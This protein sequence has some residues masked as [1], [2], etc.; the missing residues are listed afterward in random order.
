MLHVA[1][2]CACAC[3]CAWHVLLFFV[4]CSLLEL[5]RL[6]LA[7]CFVFVSCRVLCVQRL[8][9]VSSIVS[10]SPRSLPCVVLV[11]VVCVVLFCGSRPLYARLLRL[12]ACTRAR[13]FRRGGLVR[14]AESTI[15]EGGLSCEDTK[16]DVYVCVRVCR[17]FPLPPSDSASPMRVGS[18]TP[19][20]SRKARVDSR[21]AELGRRSG[22][23]QIF[24]RRLSAAI[25]AKNKP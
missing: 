16:V 25:W 6:R 3:S 13:G 18:C 11:C 15:G 17:G 12:V 24:L 10:S 21:L 9:R 14:G 5:A 1:C 7:C 8:P 19:P 2:A 20:L 23:P 22:V 4:S